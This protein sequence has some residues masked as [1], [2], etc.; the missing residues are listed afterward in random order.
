MSLTPADESSVLRSRWWGNWDWFGGG[1]GGGGRGGGPVM[2]A[3]R[4]NTMSC[5]MVA[6]TGCSQDGRGSRAGQQTRGFCPSTEMA[7][8]GQDVLENDPPLWGGLHLVLKCS[9]Q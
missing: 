1:G 7:A 9:L 2:S 5:L 8:L 6:K 4:G 3:H